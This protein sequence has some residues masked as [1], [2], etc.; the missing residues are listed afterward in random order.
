M[1]DFKSIDGQSNVDIEEFTF[2]NGIELYLHF[3]IE[4]KGLNLREAFQHQRDT[5]PLNFLTL[6]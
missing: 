5:S 2:L 4:P 3:L 1:D 6:I